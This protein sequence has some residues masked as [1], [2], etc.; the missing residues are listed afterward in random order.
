MLNTAFELSSVSMPKQTRL[1]DAMELIKPTDKQDLSIL[2]TRKPIVD[3]PVADDTPI[4]ETREEQPVA[5]AQDET[6]IIQDRQVQ[7]PAAEESVQLDLLEDRQPEERELISLEDDVNVLEQRQKPAAAQG[8]VRDESGIIRT[9]VAP[10]ET[11][12]KLET[13]VIKP[14]DLTPEGMEKMPLKRQP[15]VPQPVKQQVLSELAQKDFESS[16]DFGD[17]AKAAFAEENIM[18]WMY[19]N[20]PEFEP[21][22]D[23]MLDEKTYNE[24]VKDIPEDYRDFVLDSSSL[25]HAKALRNQVFNSMENDRKLAEY[26]WSGVGLRVAASMLDPAAVFAT[27]A[28]EGVAAPAI[29]G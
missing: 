5:L 14:E 16:V 27:V 8:I 29:V 10:A 11:S 15:F 19:R 17:A 22:P 18:S 6:P 7:E 4:I 26:G 9:R 23:F 20:S 25:A 13:D 3:A 1:A 21:D 2:E 28:T 24:L 12:L